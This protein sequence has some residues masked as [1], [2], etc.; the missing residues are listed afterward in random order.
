MSPGGTLV[1]T[2]PALQWAYSSWDRELGH[3][4]R[5]SRRQLADVLGG[6]GFRV[7][8]CNY[9]FPEMLVMLP[10]RKIRPGRRSDV[11]FPQLGPAM[12]RIGLTVSS[13]TARLRRWWPA[14]T[15]V[16][17]VATKPETDG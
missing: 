1:V 13:V 10:I 17:A 12:N 4:R 7:D 16:I 3:F 5:Y 6:A 11:D 15:S 8:E 9:L 2:V 14:G